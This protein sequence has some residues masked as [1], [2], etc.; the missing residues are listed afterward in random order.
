MSAIDEVRDRTD[1]V[2]LVSEY[3]PVK[4]QG[5]SVKALCPFHA[6]KTPS[7]VLYPDEGRWHCF[8][9]CGTGG[10]VFEFVMRV[11]NLDFRGALEH[12][13][14]R[15]GVVLEPPSAAKEAQA[16]R[17]DTLRAVLEAA[18]SFFAQALQAPAGEPAREYLAA[19]GFEAPVVEAFGLGWAPDSWNALIDHLRARGYADPLLEEAGLARPSERGGLYSLF[20]GRLVIPI[21]DRRGRAVG[22]GARTLDPAGQPKYINSPQ[23]PLFDK[24]RL[25]YALDRAAGPIRDAGV[26]VVVEGFTDVIRAHT[27]GYQNVVASLGTSLTEHHIA[28]LKRYAPTIVLALDAD[29]AGTR[30]SI[31]GLD[32]A[33]EAAG[34]EVVPVPTAQG[35]IRYEHRLEV[36]MRVATLP[37]GADPDD[38]L[39]ATPDA[40]PALIAGAKP[41]VGFLIDALTEDLDVNSPGGKTEAARRLLPVIGAVPDTVSRAAWISELADKI[42][43]DA[44]ALVAQLARQSPAR[45]NRNGPGGAPPRQA[46]LAGDRSRVPPR[47]GSAP[48]E[49]GAE[50]SASPP[51]ARRKRTPTDEVSAWILGHVLRQ[52]RLL[53]E[54]NV[55]LEALAQPPLAAEDLDNPLDRDLLEAVRNEVRGAAAPD[56]PP[57]HQLALLPADHVERADRLIAR[58]GDEPRL[59]AAE[60]VRSVRDAVLRLRERRLRQTL[61][62]LRFLQADAATDERAQFDQQ[63]RQIT[64]DFEQLQRLLAPNW[65]PQLGKLDPAVMRR[66]DI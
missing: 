55:A 30:A 21:R 63:V 39:R 25:L 43:V 1:I 20:R 38:F 22:F 66:R 40:W 44:R 15:A 59:D 62:R 60:T 61:E 41:I 16:D 32:V 33:R 49:M 51:A 58:V 19:R 24:G 6:E 57:E 3:V 10:D 8:G 48:W 47:A 14:R 52:P 2:Q 11:E 28:V 64:A 7:F 50:P 5:R 42:R 31:R 18:Q 45:P 35:W 65:R 23:S 56:T 17:R 13:A 36:E 26:A 46:G 53:T 12:L 34:G 9:A 29:A 37:A 4:K 27:A 54:T